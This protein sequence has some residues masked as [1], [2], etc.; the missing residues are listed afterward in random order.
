MALCRVISIIASK[1]TSH[2]YT[3]SK[4]QSRYVYL[5]VQLIKVFFG[6]EKKNMALT[7]LELLERGRTVCSQT[8]DDGEVSVVIRFFTLLSLLL[9]Y[10]LNTSFSCHCLRLHIH[11][12]N[13]GISSLCMSS[14]FC[15]SPAEQCGKLLRTSQYM[16]LVK[17]G[18]GSYP[19]RHC[20]RTN[21]T[22]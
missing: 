16:V 22:A 14:Q 1:D 10:A 8:T 20:L 15:Y 12:C 7:P 11:S 6:R 2:Y 3:S 9:L 5:S 4:K 17:V 19:F 13:R 21:T 18:F